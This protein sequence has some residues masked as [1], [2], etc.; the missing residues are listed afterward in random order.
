MILQIIRN[1]GRDYNDFGRFQDCLNLEGFDYLLAITSFSR[2]IN[3]PLSIGFCVPNVCKET[4]LN[5]FKPYI[6]PAI[7]TQLS[8]IF[9]QVKG[10]NSKNL[11]LKN[12]EVNLIYSKQMNQTATQFNASNFFFIF[13]VSCLI[14]AVVVSSILNYRYITQKKLE[15]I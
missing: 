12:N 8:F 2:A 11:Q 10:L 13:I 9:S 14:V 6:I 1:S 3:N 15:A 4:D 7:N 5:S